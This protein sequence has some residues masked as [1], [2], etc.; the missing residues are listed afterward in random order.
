M[1]DNLVA[2]GWESGEPTPPHQPAHEPELAAPG[3]HLPERAF[4]FVCT[5]ETLAYEEHPPRLVPNLLAV[6]VQMPLLI[7]ISDPELAAGGWASGAPTLLRQLSREMALATPAARAAMGW[8][9]G[10]GPWTLP[11]PWSALAGLWAP[12]FPHSPH[13]PVRPSDA[14]PMRTYL[15]RALTPLAGDGFHPLLVPNL[16]ADGARI[17]QVSDQQV[18]PTHVPPDLRSDGRAAGLGTFCRDLASGPWAFPRPS[19]APFAGDWNI[20]I[21]PWMPPRPPQA[22]DWDAAAADSFYCLRTR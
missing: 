16:L 18:T 7:R 5:G 3:A 12:H 14:T 17:I 8:G 10:P 15:V 9:T 20:R 22:T 6:G 13:I 11:L 19:P 4:R 2:G 21:R 1:H